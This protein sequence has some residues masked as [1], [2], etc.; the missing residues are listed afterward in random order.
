M[1]SALLL[2]LLFLFTA[3]SNSLSTSDSKNHTATTNISFTVPEYSH[4]KLWIENSYQTKIITLVN[5]SLQM[6]THTAPWGAV[7]SQGKPVPYGLYSYHLRIGNKLISRPIIYG[8][9][10]R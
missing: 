8:P 2:L 4:V 10:T 5:D 9:P 6:G 7:D 3:C 1:R